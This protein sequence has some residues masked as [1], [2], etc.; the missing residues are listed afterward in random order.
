MIGAGAV[1]CFFAAQLAAGGRAEVTVCARRPFGDLQVSS[2]L[3]G[4]T[5]RA[6]PLV[7]TD[8]AGLQAPFDAV[9]LATKAHQTAG[10]AAWLAAATGPGT[11]VAVLQ[12][13]VEQVGR[14]RPWVPSSAVVLP[15]VVYCGVERTGPGRVTHRTHGWFH[16]PDGEAARAVA[17]L[18]PPER[19]LV[20]PVADWPTTAWRK[21][22]ENVTANGVTALTGRRMEVLRDP[23][24]QE[25]LRGLLA[26]ATT[27]AASEG[28]VLPPD[29]ADRQ[30]AR[31][32]AFPDGVGTSMLYDRLGGL[33]M[34]EDAIYGAVVRAG[35]RHGVATPLNQALLTLL[36][37]ISATAAGT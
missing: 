15:A 24:V 36:A 25:L 8:P 28:A 29:Y 35:A 23:A 32:A 6:A 13:G 4:T 34:E 19:E 26:E 17:G 2:E 3:W 7:Q 5:L 10:A 1:G 14:V 22:C 16:L 33:P 37:A 31:V 20:Q 30:I 21:L 27:V 11:T 18:F 12:N 9:L